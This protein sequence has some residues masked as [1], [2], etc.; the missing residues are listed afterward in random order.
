MNIIKTFILIVLPL[1]G[2]SQVPT[3]MNLIQLAQSGATDGQFIKWDN[4]TSNWVPA[5][6]TAVTDHGALTQF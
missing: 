3:R 6:V 1:I 4:A 5:T 2:Y